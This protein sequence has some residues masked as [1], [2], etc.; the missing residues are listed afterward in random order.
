MEVIWIFID[1]VFFVFTGILKTIANQDMAYSSTRF[2]MV[3]VNA[4]ISLCG[5]AL[6]PLFVMMKK[7]VKLWPNHR[8][9]RVVL[10]SAILDATGIT[11]TVL[12]LTYAGSGLFSVV[13]ASL[14]TITAVLRWMLMSKV[15]SCFIRF[16]FP[17]FGR[18]SFPYFGRCSFPLFKILS[19]LLKGYFS[20][21]DRFY[22]WC[23]G[24]FDHRSFERR[25]SSR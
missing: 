16:S 11:F 3:F 17:N 19:C 7:R 23:D 5:G 4:M 10:F 9:R 1:Q 20:E 22:V 13:Y 15:T 14:P 18:C 12:G 25:L 21:Q 8:E 2:S 24:R 6:I